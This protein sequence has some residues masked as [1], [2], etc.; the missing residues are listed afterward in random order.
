[1]FSPLYST[2]LADQLKF[3]H[4]L[5]DGTCAAGLV[6]DAV[7]A[8][9]A[10]LFTPKLRDVG[11]RPERVRTAAAVA[12]FAPLAHRSSPVLRQAARHAAENVNA[13]AK[14]REAIQ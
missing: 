4:V 2:G 3:T 14:V 12:D 7:E 5:H 10:F 8:I 13:D 1:L 6:D 11:S 9:V